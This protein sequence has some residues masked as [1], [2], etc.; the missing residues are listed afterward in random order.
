MSLL[1][2]SSWQAHGTLRHEIDWGACCAHKHELGVPL[3]HSL[4][5]FFEAL[6]RAVRPGGIVCTQAESLWLHL[7]IIKS[8]AGMCSGVFAGGS[9][10]YAHTTIPTYP[11]CARNGGLQQGALHLWTTEHFFWVCV[12]LGP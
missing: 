11:R 9:V 2:F 8:L 10:S 4:Q 5:P 6:H 7:D 1:A 3:C 12:V